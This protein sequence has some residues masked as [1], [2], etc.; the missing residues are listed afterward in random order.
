[1]QVDYFKYFGSRR[2]EINQENQKQ[3]RVKQNSLKREKY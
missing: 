2:Q 1:M 3:D